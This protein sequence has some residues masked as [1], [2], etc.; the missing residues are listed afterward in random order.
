MARIDCSKVTQIDC[1]VV[2]EGN[3]DYVISQMIGHVKGSHGLSISESDIRAIWEKKAVVAEKEVEEAEE[4]DWSSMSVKEL[5]AEAKKLGISGYSKMKK[6]ELAEA[7]T[8]AL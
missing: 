8:E 4:S 6:A 2:F 3:E 1:P 7:L 5:R